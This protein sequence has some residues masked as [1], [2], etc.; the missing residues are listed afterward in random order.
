MIHEASHFVRNG[1]LDDY[2]YGR[3]EAQKLAINNPSQAI[4][5]ADNHEYFTENDPALS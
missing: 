3:T 4:L 2:A 1:G 5:N